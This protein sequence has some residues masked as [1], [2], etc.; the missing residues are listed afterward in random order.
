MDEL[1]SVKIIQNLTKDCKQDAV[2][3]LWRCCPKCGSNIIA[4]ICMN[5]LSLVISCDGCGSTFKVP[6]QKEDILRYIG[7]GIE[8]ELHEKYN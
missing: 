3:L 1:N 5:D 2:G 7:I 4:D 6:L 8:Y